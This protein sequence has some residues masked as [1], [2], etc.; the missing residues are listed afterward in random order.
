MSI[1]ALMRRLDDRLERNTFQTNE[2]G[3]IILHTPCPFCGE[4]CNFCTP[5]DIPI[6]AMIAERHCY[7]C[8]RTTRGVIE[9][10]DNGEPNNIT[11][12]QIAGPSKPCYC[13]IPWVH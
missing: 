11:M 13:H 12:V 6:D 10:D 9:Y 1:L 7:V 8:R 4:P 3:V 2:D 5:M